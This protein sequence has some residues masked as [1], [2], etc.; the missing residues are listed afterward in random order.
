MTQIWS[1]MRSTSFDLMGGKED[2][3]SFRAFRGQR[4]EELLGTARIESFA[5]LIENQQLWTAR[6]A[7][8]QREFRSHA[9]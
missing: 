8:D 9:F 5:W 1:E 2:R 7:E 4:F 3:C 6:D